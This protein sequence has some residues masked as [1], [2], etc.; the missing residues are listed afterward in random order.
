VKGLILQNE[1]E[2]M[3]EIANMYN[4]QYHTEK[5]TTDMYEK[6]GEMIGKMRSVTMPQTLS[7]SWWNWTELIEKR[8]ELFEFPPGFRMEEFEMNVYIITIVVPPRCLKSTLKF[9]EFESWFYKICQMEYPWIHYHVWISEDMLEE[10]HSEQILWMEWTT[11]IKENVRNPFIRVEKYKAGHKDSKD[12]FEWEDQVLGKEFDRLYEDWKTG[13]IMY[14][15]FYWMS[16]PYNGMCMKNFIERRQYWLKR[17]IYHIPIL[18]GLME[19]NRLSMEWQKEKIYMVISNSMFIRWK[20]IWEKM[21]KEK[22]QREFRRRFIE[23]MK[24]QSP[25]LL[26]EPRE[27]MDSMYKVEDIVWITD[28]LGYELM[29][30]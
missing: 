17:H 30:I 19:K 5:F 25:Q 16:L 28:K 3:K 20:T 9:V 27:G 6:L 22:R 1:W 15:R 11:M 23:F 10:Y 18:S 12:L 14:K 2:E 8:G 4:F 26:L 13:K 24:K 7:Q 21:V 29:K